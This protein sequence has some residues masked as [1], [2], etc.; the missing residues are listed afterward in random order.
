MG[1]RYNGT[2]N[3][4]SCGTINLVNSL[5]AVKNSCMKIGP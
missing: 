5:A 1:Y 4:E 3:V 2:H